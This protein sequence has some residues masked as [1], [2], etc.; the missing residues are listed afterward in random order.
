MT[1]N[2]PVCALHP[3][4]LAAGAC[5][6]CG[7]FVCPACTAPGAGLLCPTCR[8]RPDTAVSQPTPWERRAE[9]GLVQGWLQT[10]VA[11]LTRPTTFFKSVAP[12]GGLGAPL[13]Y[14]WLSAALAAPLHGLVLWASGGLLADV[15]AAFGQG[16]ELARVVEW[17]R[18][19][20]EHRAA[21]ALGVVAAQLALTP[22]TQL[23]AAGLTHLGARAWSA[24]TSSYGATFRALSYTNG[25]WLLPAALVGIVPVVNSLVGFVMLGYQVVALGQVRRTSVGRAI[26]ALLTVPLLLGC[27]G[28]AAIGVAAVGAAARLVPH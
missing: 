15:V 9:L 2:A 13:G 12:D 27:C 1:P 4:A 5:P 14:V 8:E 22:V 21:L 6:R 17:A 3:E 26:G 20:E 10:T 28:A 11:A 23:F 19:A 24:G 16:G 25:A 18:Y 7:A